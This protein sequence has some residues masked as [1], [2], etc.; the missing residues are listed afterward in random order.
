MPVYIALLNR[1]LVVT[2]SNVR[3]EALNISL[4]MRL[5]LSIPEEGTPVLVAIA[6]IVVF[7]SRF[8]DCLEEVDGLAV[9]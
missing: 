4:N 2:T 5:N 8:F 3:R 9:S 6:D 7:V 1:P